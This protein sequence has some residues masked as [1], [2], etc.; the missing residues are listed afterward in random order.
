[1]PEF[2]GTPG[3]WELDSERDEFGND[4]HKVLGRVLKSRAGVLFDTLNSDHCLAP[5]ER[6]ANMAMAAASPLAY[7]ILAEL[8]E[9]LHD[10][11]GLGDIHPTWTMDIKKKIAAYFSKVEVANAL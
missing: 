11:T 8:R 5:E 3:E 2:K 4:Q 1:M 10:P 7:S 6:R 9:L